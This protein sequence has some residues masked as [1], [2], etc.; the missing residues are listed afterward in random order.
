MRALRDSLIRASLAAALLATL[1]EAAPVTNP[2]F[3][4]AIGNAWTYR[5]SIEGE[6][7]FDKTLRITTVGRD[8]DERVYH[9][10]LRVRGD[11]QPLVLHLAL[12]PS[13]DVL[14]SFGSPT[15]EREL[16]MTATPK[17]GDAIG[18]WR[19]GAVVPLDTPARKALPA[20]RV[21]TFDIDDPALPTERRSEW[22]ARFYA[23]GI[24]P[25]GEADGLGGECLL[26][27][28]YR[29]NP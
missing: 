26:L 16:L 11:T 14:R 27:R 9:A 19:V 7:Q 6:H 3:P 2:Y 21:E 20:L 25:V 1:A 23:K 4:L 24:G 12:T 10:E 28:F 15:A 13:G 29:H 22:R 17:P 18:G 8:G 5:C